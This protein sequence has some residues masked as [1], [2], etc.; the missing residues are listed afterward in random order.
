MRIVLSGV[1][2][3]KKKERRSDMA[4]TIKGIDLG[5][6]WN[7]YKEKYGTDSLYL[8]NGY[9]L[10]VIVE[11]TGDNLLPE[12]EENGYVDYWMTNYYNDDDADGGQ[13]METNLIAEI[14][15]T[16]QGVI[17]RILQ[18]SDS[19]WVFI[20]PKLGEET[21]DAYEDYYTCR[22]FLRYMKQL[23]NSML[24]I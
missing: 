7:D 3:V 20:E 14:D 10:F 24:D 2:S 23:I 4:M 1:E 22:N 16:I 13:W 9:T 8:W 17:N 12:D 21:M 19:D 18:C 6:K 15:Y 11:G 5:M